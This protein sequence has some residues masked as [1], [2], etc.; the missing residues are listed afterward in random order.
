MRLFRLT[1]IAVAAALV[2]AQPAAAIG[3]GRSGDH[4]PLYYLSLGDSLA[5]GEQPV[6]D[7]VHG[8][9]T[10]E[11][12]AEQLLAIAR[13]WYPN[14]QLVKLGCSGGETTR[15]MIEGGICAYDHGSQLD[16][17]LAFLHA[18]G[19][20]VAFI[21]ID[22][23]INDFPCQDDVG[24]VEG[25]LLTIGANLPDILAQLREAAGPE[26]PIVGMNYYDPILG[27]WLTGAAGQVI[28]LQSIGIFQYINGVFGTIYGAAYMPIADVMG[29]FETTN[30]A[31]FALP[32]FGTV[33][34][35]VARICQYTWVCTGPPYG[36]NNHANAA[37]YGVMAQAFATALGH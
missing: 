15:T 29:A 7:G 14:L 33:P 11:G 1:V 18:H 3:P 27:Y 20:F 23:G 10:S 2:I 6:G 22:I 37:G 12:Y 19:K 21:T 30:G 34:T 9:P 4:A 26:T 13:A 16:E 36:P 25:G 28:A 17:A 8:A 5:A 24:C 32:P 31:P 35:N